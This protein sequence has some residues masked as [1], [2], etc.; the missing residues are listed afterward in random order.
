MSSF[1]MV[2]LLSIN[3]S[4]S[5]FIELA[6]IGGIVGFGLY[7]SVIRAAAAMPDSEIALAHVPN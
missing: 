5:T 1:Q 3:A 6:V 4:S 2:G 7:P